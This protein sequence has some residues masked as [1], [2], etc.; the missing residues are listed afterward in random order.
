MNLSTIKPLDMEGVVALARET[1]AI[2]TVEEHQV[3]GGMGGAVAE[4]LA[5]VGRREAGR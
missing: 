5:E 3:A 4:V 1:K 2:V